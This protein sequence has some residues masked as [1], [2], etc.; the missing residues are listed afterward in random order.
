MFIL[1]Y[2]LQKTHCPN[3]FSRIYS[4]MPLGISHLNSTTRHLSRTSVLFF[5][6]SHPIEQIF[7]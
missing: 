1:T 6:S 4:S 2:F 5:F 3:L 7:Y